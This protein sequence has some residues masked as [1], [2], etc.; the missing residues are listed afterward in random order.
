[1]VDEGLSLGGEQ[2]GHIIFRDHATTG[3]G[4]LTGLL[5]LHALLDEEETLEELVDG[6]VPCPQILLNVR[7]TEKP[8]LRVHPQIGPEVARIEGDLAGSGRVVLRYSGTEPLARV[9]VE[10]RDADRVRD[11]AERLAGLIRSELGA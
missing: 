1:M 11:H 9:M 7:V 5:L 3:D 10:G 2:S 8:D 4:I 6:I